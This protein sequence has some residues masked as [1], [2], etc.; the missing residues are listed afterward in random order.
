MSL[1]LAQAK[2]NAAIVSFFGMKV[3][4]SYWPTWW[5]FARCITSSL[6]ALPWSH[7]ILTLVALASNSTTPACGD[8]P[9][10]FFGGGSFSDRKRPA[11]IAMR[12]YRSTLGKSTCSASLTR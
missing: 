4:C 10:R 8:D 7:R 3:L 5:H 9:V 6:T 12:R 1:S 11:I 2:G